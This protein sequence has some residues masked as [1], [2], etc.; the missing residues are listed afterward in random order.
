MKN[1]LLLVLLALAYIP[2]VSFAQTIKIGPT[3]SAHTFRSAN[4]DLFA[5]RTADQIPTA[6]AVWNYAKGYLND[7]PIVISSLTNNDVLKY[8]AANTRWINSAVSGGSGTVTSV[9]LSLPNIFSVSGSPV[10]SSG[11]LSAT[12]ATQTANTV[13]A[14]PTTG[15]ASAPTFRSLVTADLSDGLVTSA[16]ILDGTIATGDLADG[17]VTSAKIA[18]ATIATGD[19]ADGAVTSAKI[20]DGTI[21][22]GDLADGAV[23]SAKITDATIATGDLADGAVTSA[24]IATGAVG[25]TAL[26]STAVTAG[27]YTSANI[28]VDA[29]GRITAA[30][31]GSGGGGGGTT[32]SSYF[33][34]ASNGSTAYIRATGTG[35]TF[36]RTGTTLIF[37]IPAGV[38]ILYFRVYSSTAISGNAFL[39]F[40][41]A[42]N[43]TTNQDVATAVVPIISGLKQAGTSGGA[44][45]ALPHDYRTFGVAATNVLGARLAAV[46]SGNIEIE[47]SNYSTV[48]GT[49]HSTIFGHF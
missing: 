14:G 5:A 9:G 26:A 21:A 15:T 19:L 40:N 33:T 39:D 2:L 27:S 4:T 22:T 24:K 11:T 44:V 20:L 45:G 25:A 43:T 1:R 41:Y 47:I 8:D 34:A 31:N 48:L 30:S 29:D 35:V 13:F 37:D 12:L 38:E 7:K 18:D 36:T 23:T 3:G 17:A 46:G 42:S 6:L 10:T 32:I 49:G 16:K 28:T